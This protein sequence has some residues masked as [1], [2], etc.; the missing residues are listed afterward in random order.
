MKDRSNMTE[1][2]CPIWQTSATYEPRTGDFSIIN[3]PRASG[4]YWIDGTAKALCQHLNDQDK[5]RLTSEIIDQRISGIELPKVNGDTIASAKKRKALRYGQ[6]IERLF[7]WF[8]YENFQPGLHFKIDSSDDDSNKTLAE[9]RA[10]I[11][12]TNEAQ[13]EEYLALLVDDQ[14]LT[15][16]RAV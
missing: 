3:S 11:E 4:R 14:Y 5:V 1:N 12:D 13:L 15:L 2:K 8:N 9:G 7:R 6:K 16:L 10:W